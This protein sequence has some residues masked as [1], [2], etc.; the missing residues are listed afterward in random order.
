MSQEGYDIENDA[1]ITSMHA[2][3]EWPEFTVGEIPDAHTPSGLSGGTILVGPRVGKDEGASA[4]I[5]KIKEDVANARGMA[6][7]APP[8]RHRRGPPPIIK[9]HFF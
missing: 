7:R 8:H 3:P 6:T 9:W 4:I 2:S 1:R 5:F